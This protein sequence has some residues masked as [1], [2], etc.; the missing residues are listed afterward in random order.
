MGTPGNGVV[1]YNGH[2]YDV[3][4]LSGSDASLFPASLAF[5]SD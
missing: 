4:N 1:D 3:R 2:S 5:T